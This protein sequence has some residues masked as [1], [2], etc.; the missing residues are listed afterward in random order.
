[1]SRTW[2]AIVPCGSIEDIP[3]IRGGRW[4]IAQ[5]Q[6]DIGEEYVRGGEIGSAFTV[7]AAKGAASCQR[8]RAQ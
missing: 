1:M 6:P 3:D 7:S 2:G 5:F 4:G 8:P